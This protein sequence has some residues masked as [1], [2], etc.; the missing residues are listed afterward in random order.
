L[1]FTSPNGRLPYDPERV[2]VR[3]RFA[4][5]LPDCVS[6]EIG[7]KMLEE[8]KYELPFYIVTAFS[9]ISI[10]LFYKV[11]KNAGVKDEAE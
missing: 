5:R 2:G 7:G 6:T 9:S 10:A 11:F 3:R 1:L 4:G 8:G